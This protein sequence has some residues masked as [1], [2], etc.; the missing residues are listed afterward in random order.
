M[1][2]PNAGPSTSLTITFRLDEVSRQV[3]AER[4]ARLHVSP[5]RLARD[6]VSRA[7]VTSSAR[8]LV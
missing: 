3:L 6:Y 8:M 2:L 7:G 4:A 5:H 1:T